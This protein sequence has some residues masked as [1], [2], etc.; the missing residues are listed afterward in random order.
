MGPTQ[1]QVLVT[2]GE[3]NLRR[4]VEANQIEEIVPAQAQVRTALQPALRGVHPCT[5]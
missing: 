2:M 3:Q 1:P 5:A 4:R